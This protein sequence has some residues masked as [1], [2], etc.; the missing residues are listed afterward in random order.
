MTAPKKPQDH[1]VKA[2]AAGESVSFD[3]DGLTYTIDRGNVDNLELMEFVE[4]E[5]YLSAI[6][7]YLGPDQ[8]VKW[9]DAHRDDK[10][11]VKSEHFEPFMQHVMDSIGGRGN[12]SASSGS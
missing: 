1:L 8:W 11:R 10:G 7:G 12:S 9:K 5:K 3:Y 2:E 6:R 4:D